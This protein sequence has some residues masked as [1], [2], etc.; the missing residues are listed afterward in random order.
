ASSVAIA[1]GIAG[2]T[3]S[4]MSQ[5]ATAQFFSNLSPDARA[6]GSQQ[7]TLTPSVSIA[8]TAPFSNA[9]KVA[10]EAA[11]S[12]LHPDARASDLHWPIRISS[13]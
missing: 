5:T 6:G 2:Q 1:P 10:A 13:S 7:L 8:P 11:V 12:T 9:L 3:S 4:S